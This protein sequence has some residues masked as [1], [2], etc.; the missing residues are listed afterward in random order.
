MLSK[1]F[2]IAVLFGELHFIVCGDLL[3]VLLSVQTHQSSRNLKPDAWA[4]PA[5]VVAAVLTLPSSAAH[6]HSPYR[7]NRLLLPER[8]VWSSLLWGCTAAWVMRHRTVTS[9]ACG[10]NSGT[11]T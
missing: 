10:R 5:E 8:L 3:F 4:A 6:W 9:G 1:Y 7:L 11:A 2:A